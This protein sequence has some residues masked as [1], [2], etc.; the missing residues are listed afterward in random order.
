MKKIFSLLVFLVL[1]ANFLGAQILTSTGAT[2]NYIISN[3]PG[4][5]TGYYDGFSVIF[6]AN[7]ANP[8]GVATMNIA[9]VGAKNIVNTAGNALDINDIRTDQ[10]VTLIYDISAGGRFQM[11]TT[12]GN[13]GAGGAIT[14]GGTASYIPRW[15]TASTL[16]TSVIWDDGTNIG[17]GTT[18]PGA[19]LHVNPTSTVTATDFKNIQSGITFN[20]PAITNWYGNYIS[21]PTGTGIITNKYAFVTEVN[22]GKVG[23]GTITPSAPLHVESTSTVTA[24]ASTTVYFNGFQSNPNTSSFSTLNVNSSYTSPGGSLSSLFGIVTI[25][26]NTNTGTVT[27]SYGIFSRTD[28]M[29]VGG[30]IT[31]AYGLYVADP[32]NNGTITNKYAFVTEANAGKVGIGT[33]APT[34]RLQIH[35]GHIKSTQTTAPAIAI[36]SGTLTPTLDA[37]STDV[38]GSISTAGFMYNNGYVATYRITFNMPYT[39]APV[40]VASAA[41]GGILELGIAVESVSMNDVVISIQ[42][43]SLGVLAN[44]KINYIVIE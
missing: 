39:I 29:V 27:N 33:I 13:V 38:K 41:G 15:A 23:I 1:A 10:I 11:I 43:N 26:R 14:G 8:V 7:H 22:A 18:G 34:A 24:S 17:I 2:G 16:T 31:N 9:S 42:N 37:G 28:N 12:S 20:G 25:P 44:P 36:L 21:T 4:N 35:D 40:V 32:I 30:V 3:Y 19:I 5:F 6:R